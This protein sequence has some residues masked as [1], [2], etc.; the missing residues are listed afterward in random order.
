MQ[1]L[2]LGIGGVKV[3]R[4]LG[5]PAW[6]MNEGHSAFLQ[7]ERLREMVEDRRLSFA[8]AQAGL[9]RDSVFTTHT[10]VPAGNEQYDRA[11]VGRY[12]E[13]ICERIGIPVDFALAYGDAGRGEGNFNLTALALRTSSFANGVSRLNAEVA[14]RMW[15]PL[16][17]PDASGSRATKAIRPITN[18]VHP[19][20]WVGFRMSA[21]RALRRPRLAVTAPRARLEAVENIPGE[22]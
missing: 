5:I 15:Q 4:A 1:E 12:L 21:V 19:Q 10:P 8:E 11:L 13:G 7:F 6:H 18:G 17:A 14:D 22:V 9:E 20:T 2:V 16:F 3:L